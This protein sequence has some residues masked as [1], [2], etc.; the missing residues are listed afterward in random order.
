MAF[1]AAKSA[2][3]KAPRRMKRSWRSCH[4]P[5]PHRT[6]HRQFPSPRL[7]RMTSLQ[8]A[9]VQLSQ[10]APQ[11][12]FAVKEEGRRRWNHGRRFRALD[13]HTGDAPVKNY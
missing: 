12:D 6:P 5:Y 8:L 7:T 4:R 9:I 1:V 13:M 11:T 10:R 3:A 2:R